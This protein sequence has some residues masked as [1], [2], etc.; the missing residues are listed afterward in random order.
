MTEEMEDLTQDTE[1]EHKLW[2]ASIEMTDAVLNLKGRRHIGMQD[3]YSITVV[4]WHERFHNSPCVQYVPRIQQFYGRQ[5]YH[6]CNMGYRTDTILVQSHSH[7][8]SQQQHSLLLHQ[9]SFHSLSPCRV[10]FCSIHGQ[11][12]HFYYLIEVVLILFQFGLSYLL[13]HFIC[14]LNITFQLFTMY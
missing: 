1:P 9:Q 13:E 12:D 2:G 6:D 8:A 10:L 14:I 4:F 11:C 7:L 3:Q 5:E